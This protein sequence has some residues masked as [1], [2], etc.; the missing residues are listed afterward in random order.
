VSV[1]ASRAIVS[2]AGLG[3]QGRS[4]GDRL[5]Q[6]RPRLVQRGEPGCELPA[7][8]DPQLPGLRK[9]RKLDLERLGP[10]AERRADRVEHRRRRRRRQRTLRVQQRLGERVAAERLQRREQPRGLLAPL[11]QAES[12][13]ALAGRGAGHR[14]AERRERRVMVGDGDA[15]RRERIRRLARRRQRRSRAPEGGGGL[16]DGLSRRRGGPGQ[17]EQERCGPLHAASIRLAP[18]ISGGGA[19]PISARSVGARSA[20]CPASRSRAPAGPPTSTT[21]TGFRVWAVCGPPLAGSIIV[22]AP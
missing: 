3:H 10:G 1:S 2:S 7:A 18:V 16:G 17:S 13:L 5:P 15:E 21:G 20:S 12:D 4:R 8:V 19:R 22:S 14:R 6:V 9:R 11:G